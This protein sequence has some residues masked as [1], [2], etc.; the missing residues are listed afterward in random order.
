MADTPDWMES[1]SDVPLSIDIRAD[2]DRWGDALARSLGGGMGMRST[3]GEPFFLEYSSGTLPARLWLILD[4]L[5]RLHPVVVGQGE[6]VEEQVEPWRRAVAEATSALARPDETFPWRAVVG[7]SPTRRCVVELSEPTTVGGLILR[8]GGVRHVDYGPP[9]IPQ[10]GSRMILPSWPFFVEGEAEGYNWNVASG[11]AARCLHRL[12]GLVSLAWGSH[13]AVRHLPTPA[14]RALTAIPERDPFE[15]ASKVPADTT[16]STLSALPSWLSEAWKRLDSD[17]DLAN[18]VGVHYEGL[19]LREQHPSFA[20]VAFVAAIETVGAIDKPPARCETCNGLPGAIERFRTGLRHVM[21]D[22]KARALAKDVYQ[23]RSETAHS[24][25]LHGSERHRGAL[26]YMG[27]FGRPPEDDFSWSIA[28]RVENASRAVL[29]HVLSR[30]FNG[31]DE[32][33]LP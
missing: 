14:S 23:R 24:G 10:Y 18:A 30:P 4:R 3:P 29:T 26:P 32:S 21:A 13:W 25:A 33:T 31:G 12:T 17:A 16:A 11:Q 28:G 20:V 5:G 19:A 6:R 22:G 8:P 2:C 15:D 7:P 27:F 9:Q 1:A